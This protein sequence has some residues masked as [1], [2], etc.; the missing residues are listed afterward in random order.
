M[1]KFGV[2]WINLIIGILL[3]VLGIYFCAGNTEI[4]TKILFVIIGI[5]MVITNIFPLINSINRKDLIDIVARIIFIVFGILFIFV[6]NTALSIIVGIIFIA[7]PI[8]KVLLA[9]DKMTMFMINLPEILIGII[10]LIVGP[11]SVSKT[12]FIVL[13][14]F[15]IIFGILDIL[16][17]FYK[18]EIIKE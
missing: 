7:F 15:L 10:I 5:L 13:G 2:N 18:Q 8:I 6:H 4:L 1:K 14:I 17:S 12:L 11:Q 3:F 16:G 9:S